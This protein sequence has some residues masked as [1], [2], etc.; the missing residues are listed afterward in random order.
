MTGRIFQGHEV[1]QPY[2][3]LIPY[4]AFSLDEEHNKLLLL[5]L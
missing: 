3:L 4:R 1:L 2:Q 5:Q